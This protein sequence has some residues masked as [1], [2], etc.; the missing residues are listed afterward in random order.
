MGSTRGTESYFILQVVF[1][2]RARS[3]MGNMRGK[4]GVFMRPVGIRG[5]KVRSKLVSPFLFFL[6]VLLEIGN[7]HGEGVFYDDKGIKRFE[8]QFNVGMFNGKGKWY[9]D[10]GKVKYEGDWAMG[11]QHGEGVEFDKEGTQTFAG[12]FK[13]GKQVKN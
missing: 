1:S 10:S 4:V 7:P 3:L 12:L 9:H 6:L 2:L 8:G 13:N 5:T 11:K